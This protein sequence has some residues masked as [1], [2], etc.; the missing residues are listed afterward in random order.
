MKSIQFYIVLS[1]FYRV[2]KR[3]GKLLFTSN[4]NNYCHYNTIIN[5]IIIR[6][7]VLLFC[8]RELCLTKG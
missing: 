5:A 6:T 2:R 7:T 3:H 1:W 8:T 4:M